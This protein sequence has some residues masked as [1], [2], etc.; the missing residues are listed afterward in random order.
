LIQSID[1]DRDVDISVDEGLLTISGH[2][3]QRHEVR[4]RSESSYGSITDS[5][6]LPAD[7][8]QR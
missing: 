7:L 3:E 1:P 8:D 2:H 6:H 4:E 5:L